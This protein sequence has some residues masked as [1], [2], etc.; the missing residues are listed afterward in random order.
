MDDQTLPN[1][2]E[3]TLRGIVFASVEDEARYRTLAQRRHYLRLQLAGIDRELDTLLRRAE[4]S[5]E[6]ILENDG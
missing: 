5:A 1:A 2:V 3:H 4:W 6:A